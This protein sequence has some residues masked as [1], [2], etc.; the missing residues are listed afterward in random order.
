MYGHK[1]KLGRLVLKMGG[2]KGSDA[3]L[4]MPLRLTYC[5]PRNLQK[6][7]PHSS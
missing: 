2:G 7:L 5:L 6:V 1:D 4:N 3:F